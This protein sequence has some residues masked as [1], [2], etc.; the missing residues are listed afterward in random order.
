MNRKATLVVFVVLAIVASSL[1]SMDS[2]AVPPGSRLISWLAAGDSYSSGE[3]L[4]H[5]IGPCAQADGGASRTWAEVASSDLRSAGSTPRYADPPV[6]AACTGA[7]TGEFLSSSDAAGSP[8]W[9]PAMGRFDL[10]SFTFGGDDIGFVPIIE[11]CLGLSQLIAS[12]ED[13]GSAELG[14]AHSVS[15][16]PTDP[17][18]LC[19]KSSIIRSRI[20]QLGASYSAFLD[21]VAN[22]VVQPGGNI[23][24][25]GY[26]ELVELP[27]L[28]SSWERDLGI[29]WGIGENDANELRGIAGDLNATIGS[30]VTAF[31]NSSATSRDGVHAT[32]VDANSANGSTAPDDPDLFEPSTGARHNLCSADPWIN[33]VSAIDTFNGSFHPKQQGLD[34]EGALA[35]SVI[36]HLDWSH[37]IQV[38]GWSQPTGL[39][40]TGLELTGISC[41]TSTFCMAIGDVYNNSASSSTTP[42]DGAY[43]WNGASWGPAGDPSSAIPVH[44]TFAGW[45]TGVSC[46]SPTMC[47]ATYLDSTQNIGTTDYGVLLWN[48]TAWTDTGFPDQGSQLNGVDCVTSQ[49]CMTIT[50]PGQDIADGGAVESAI[51][52]GNRWTF[53]TLTGLTVPGTT[54]FSLACPTTSFCVTT[55]NI[56]GEIMDSGIQASQDNVS[57]VWNGTSW[58][59][60][61]WPTQSVAV[62]SL[63]CSSPTICLQLASP[64][65]GTPGYGEG[66]VAFTWNGNAWSENPSPIPGQMT[67]T[68]ISCTSSG[69]CLAVGNR[70]APGAPFGSPAPTVVDLWDGWQW[71]TIPWPAGV[72][73]ANLS[74]ASCSETDL[75]GVAGDVAGTVSF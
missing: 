28:W 66:D 2:G 29:C 63:S 70:Y 53:D 74:G 67:S 32:F 13:A 27:Q 45:L 71:L 72:G 61:A 26:P 6:N 21:Q 51:W 34:H 39:S 75:C 9:N 41:P 46:S 57:Y 54:P 47:L 60:T 64:N 33:G 50:D 7:T 15:P 8:E 65:D 35:A 30:A 31:D 58:S 36:A 12:G 56:N 24:V 22:D 20:A 17:G 69:A 38:G 62:G 3:G 23:V 68:A 42:D 5:A 55:S 40:P 48:G 59:R 43:I 18:H 19:P 37:L 4:P 1:V 44:D 52:D 10:V 25:L 14:I 16:L 73:D 49:W 11:Q